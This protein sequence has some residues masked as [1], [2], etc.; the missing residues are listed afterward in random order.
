[1]ASMRELPSRFLRQVASRETCI[2]I[3]GTERKYRM[4][5]VLVVVLLLAL[6]ASTGLALE[7][8]VKYCHDHGFDPANLACGTCALVPKGQF[9][10]KCMTCCADWLDTT[11]TTKPYRSAVLIQRGRANDEL[12]SFLKEDWEEVVKTVTPKRLSK[13]QVEGGGASFSS[14]YSLFSRLKPSQILFFDANIVASNDEASLAKL[15]SDAY[16]LDVL[17]RDDIKDMLLTLLPQIVTTQ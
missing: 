6:V 14:P 11:R 1:M 8:K 10:S 17:K 13:I 15:A 12:E 3:Q 4:P 5:A 9:Q 7:D 16:D 2:K